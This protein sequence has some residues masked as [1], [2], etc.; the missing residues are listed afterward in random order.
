M[1]GFTCLADLRPN[2]IGHL[3]KGRV[4]SLFYLFHYYQFI[5]IEY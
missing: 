5:F 4:N 2:E 1:P 3:K